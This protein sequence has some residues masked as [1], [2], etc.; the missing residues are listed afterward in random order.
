MD[1]KIGFLKI[2]INNKPQFLKIIN[3]KIITLYG[4]KY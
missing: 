1:K 2:I 3:R 4:I